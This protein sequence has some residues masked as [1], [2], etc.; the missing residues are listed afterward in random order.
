[1]SST[2]DDKIDDTHDEGD[3][4]FV[5]T[6]TK[7]Y[8]STISD[9]VSDADPSTVVPEKEGGDE[10][11]GHDDIIDDNGNKSH[12]DGGV[13]GGH[14]DSSLMVSPAKIGEQTSSEPKGKA[15]ANEKDNSSSMSGEFTELHNPIILSYFLSYSYYFY[16]YYQ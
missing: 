12:I 13:I 11:K 7:A 6:L 14:D 9:K 15:A 5:A 8:K 1:M 10:T 4:C 3:G 16:Y 2:K